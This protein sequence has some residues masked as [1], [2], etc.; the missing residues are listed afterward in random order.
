MRFTALL[1]LFLA[2]AF[3]QAECRPPANAQDYWIEQQNDCFNITFAPQRQFF[4]SAHR[5][6]NITLRPRPNIQPVFG[7]S[8][9][10]PSII[11][12]TGTDATPNGSHFPLIVSTFNNK[13]RETALK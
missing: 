9:E 13:T 8:T 4:D 11:F 3:V 5:T 2:A 1:A 10:S 12:N 6:L 7:G